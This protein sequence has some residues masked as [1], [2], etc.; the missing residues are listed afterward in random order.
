MKNN[1]RT[2]RPRFPAFARDNRRAAGKERFVRRA[3][4]NWWIMAALAV[5]ALAPASAKAGIIV[6][7][8]EQA[9]YD[10]AADPMFQSVG[11]FR[12]VDASGA[13]IAGSGV[14]IS[15]EW[16]L[17]AGHVLD[18]GWTSVQFLLDQDFRDP[19]RTLYSADA[20]YMYPG[21]VS[22][23]GAGTNN[24]IALV[25]LSTPILGVTPADIYWGEVTPG[26]HA[27][28]AGYGRLGYYPSGETT[29]SGL[30]MGG[31][32]V[33]DMVGDPSAGIRTQ[34]FISDFGPVWTTPTL[35]LEMGITNGDSGSG[36]FADYDGQMQL[37]GIGTFIRGNYYNS[38]S[39]RPAVYR[40]WIESYVPLSNVPEPTSALLLLTTMPFVLHRRRAKRCS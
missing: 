28:W 12:G 20:W 3:I 31:E 29:T 5:A 24:D 14:L 6:A 2:A 19:N 25:H 34:F 26:T 35:A 4:R 9:H 17:T 39:I 1:T 16:V 21:F 32:N 37:I 30:K 18:N 8:T 13:Y 40:D 15:P 23:G 27:Y 36:W 33:V 38:G 22:D 11:A 10:F 7:G